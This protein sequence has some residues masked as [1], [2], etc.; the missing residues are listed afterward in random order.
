VWSRDGRQVY[1]R[2]ADQLVAVTFATTPLFK[3]TS[4]TVMFE[5]SYVSGALAHASYDISPDGKQFLLL[6]T[7]EEPLAMV[8][9]D[10]RYELRA[11]M[12]QQAAGK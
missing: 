9:H 11:H 8:V 10:W 7:A 3:V 2:R 4:S 12:K 5:G 1:Y 6:K